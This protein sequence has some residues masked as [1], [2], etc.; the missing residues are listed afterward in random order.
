[1]SPVRKPSSSAAGDIFGTRA[2]LSAKLQHG[3]SPNGFRSPSTPFAATASP[4]IEL[5]TYCGDCAPAHAA[6]S[7][8]YALHLSHHG[9][10]GGGAGTPQP[11]ALLHLAPLQAAYIL[12][13]SSTIRR[14]SLVPS[15]S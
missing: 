8:I 14:A 9:G 12:G 3:L 13:L 15:V 4:L 1:M 10:G 5:P 7:A 2:P 6:C 11:A